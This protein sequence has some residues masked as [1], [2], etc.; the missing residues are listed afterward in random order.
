VCY[1][2]FVATALCRRATSAG[3]APTQRGGYNIDD[4]ASTRL[5]TDS[6]A[7]AALDENV[8]WPLVSLW[9]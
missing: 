9:L 6:G 3:D 5:L 1:A 8:E 7:D 2:G 4:M